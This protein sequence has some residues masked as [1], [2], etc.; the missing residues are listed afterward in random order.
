[1]L[2]ANVGRGMERVDRR[3][4]LRT[5]ITARVAH[6]EFANIAAARGQETIVRLFVEC[7][8]LKTQRRL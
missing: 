4:Q 5:C 1:M 2:S 6:Y 3:L 8:L 7:F